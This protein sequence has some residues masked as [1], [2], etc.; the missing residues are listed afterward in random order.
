LQ[1]YSEMALVGLKP[2]LQIEI[3][4]NSAS[5]DGE[6]LR[7]PLEVSPFRQMNGSL[8]D[9]KLPSRKRFAKRNQ[10]KATKCKVGVSRPCEISKLSLLPDSA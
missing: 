2:R 1:N 3:A 10:I 8:P 6:T 4:K 9:W 5:R 7:F